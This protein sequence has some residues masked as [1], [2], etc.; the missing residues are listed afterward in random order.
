MP[1]NNHHPSVTSFIASGSG[2]HDASENN[3]TLRVP[4]LP[5]NGGVKNAIN[6]QIFKI[7]PTTQQICGEDHSRPPSPHPRLQSFASASFRLICD[8]PRIYLFN[9]AI[10]SKPVAITG[11]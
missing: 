2:N 4:F 3:P 9:A 10:P 1:Q 7:H 11:R 6:G 8:L 5:S